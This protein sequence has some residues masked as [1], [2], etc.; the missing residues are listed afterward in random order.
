MSKKR[1]SPDSSSYQPN[2]SE[3]ILSH[4]LSGKSVYR[5]KKILWEM[6]KKRVKVSRQNYYQN[7]YRLSRRGYLELKNDSYALTTKG[8]LAYLNPYRLI[9][10]KPE[11]KKKII[12][13]F[14]IPEPKK[15]IREWLRGQ[16]K[17]WD[18]KMIQKSVW[19]GSGP[20]PA[21]FKKRLKD[22]GIEKSV[23]IFAI[24]LEK[25]LS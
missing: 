14:D 13:I 23:L 25:Q 15:K 8:K 2:I 9:R 12:V 18:F 22:L 7:L 6:V 1:I 24:K 19:V 3:E 21:D 10:T 11:S 16:L 5:Q 20:L 4:F 17:W